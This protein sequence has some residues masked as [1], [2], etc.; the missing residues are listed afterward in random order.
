M[1]VA[2]HSK[3]RQNRV[4]TSGSDSDQSQFLSYYD[5]AVGIPDTQGWETL[6]CLHGYKY[7]SRTFF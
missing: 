4:S 7:R 6:V 1:T 3:L 2:D 5:S